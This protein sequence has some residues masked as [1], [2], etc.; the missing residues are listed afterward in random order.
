MQENRHQIELAALHYQIPFESLRR[1]SR[2][3]RQTVKP[4]LCGQPN[5]RPNQEGSMTAT[6][7]RPDRPAVPAKLRRLAAAVIAL[8]VLA[9]V[10][11]PAQ[12]ARS[13]AAAGVTAVVGEGWG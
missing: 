3:I 7:L 5:F 13:G 9:A 1:L 6:S 2:I 12:A 8:A 10:I 4:Q 11:P